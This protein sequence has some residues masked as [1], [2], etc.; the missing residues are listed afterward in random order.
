MSYQKNPFILFSK[1]SIQSTALAVLFC[2]YATS[3]W[4]GES[5]K[6]LFS[7]ISDSADFF[8]KQER[9]GKNPKVIRNRYIHINSELLSEEEPSFILNLFDD[10]SLIAKKEQITM[11]RSNRLIWKGHVEGIKDSEIFLM[12]REDGPLSVGKIMTSEKVYKIRRVGKGIY[13]IYEIDPNVLPEDG[14][15]VRFPVM[16]E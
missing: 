9:V 15:T 8:A 13:S 14:P 1:L 6:E 10:V 4:A 16:A 5:P 12:Y 2:F 11:E 3:I 7:N